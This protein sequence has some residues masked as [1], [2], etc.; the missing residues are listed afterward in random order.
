MSNRDGRRAKLNRS[1]NFSQ[2]KNKCPICAS[3]LDKCG[4]YNLD[5]HKHHRFC[6]KCKYSNF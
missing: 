5:G 2:P 3:T 4:D 1:H 6:K